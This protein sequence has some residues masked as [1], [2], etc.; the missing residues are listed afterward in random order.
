MGGKIGRFLI[1]AW[2][3]LG[4][5]IEENNRKRTI[6]REERDRQ[7][8]AVKPVVNKILGKILQKRIEEGFGIDL[9]DLDDSPS[10]K[11][12]VGKAESHDVYGRKTEV[13]L[14]MTKEDRFKH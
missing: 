5:L 2:E 7:Y 8:E 6:E 13:K 1:A 9:S 10:S 12:T 4:A 3:R 14:T 11:T